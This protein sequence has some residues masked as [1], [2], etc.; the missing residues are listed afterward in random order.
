MD[1]AIAL[2]V[3]HVVRR[4]IRD[5]FAANDLAAIVLTGDGR[6]QHFHVRQGV[7]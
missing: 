5:R 7:A 1:A 2:R 4:F 3:R 6:G